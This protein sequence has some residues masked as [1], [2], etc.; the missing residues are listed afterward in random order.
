MNP[1]EISRYFFTEGY[2][3]K[4]QKNV[5]AF[6]SKPVIVSTMN[7]RANC[8]SIY[9]VLENCGFLLFNRA[10]YSPSDEGEGFFN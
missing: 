3:Y 4:M 5:F 7:L 9:S 1:M 2:R 6:F 10:I 8:F